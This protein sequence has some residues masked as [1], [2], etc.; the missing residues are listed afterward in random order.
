MALTLD[1]LRTSLTYNKPNNL[2]A[3]KMITDV[4]RS[5]DPQHIKIA[6]KNIIE[7]YIRTLTSKPEAEEEVD[8]KPDSIVRS[9]DEQVA[10]KYL[11]LIKSARN[12]NKEFSLTLS[13][14]RKL[15]RI[16]K[17]HYTGV[18]FGENDNAM[19]VD[20]I[21]STKGYVKGNVVACTH[22]ANRT[23]NAV[24]ELPNGLAVNRTKEFQSLINKVSEYVLVSD[25][26]D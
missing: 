5:N 13:D 22:W 17:C 18:A 16:K 1:E 7:E 24:Y 19:T 10:I 3:Q 14:V 2:A 6:K 11:Q 4:L 26:I 9:E 8:E 15:L 23:K 25:K 21:D 20:R 12:R